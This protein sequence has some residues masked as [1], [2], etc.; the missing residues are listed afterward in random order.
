MQLALENHVGISLLLAIASLTAGAACFQRSVSGG[1]RSEAGFDAGLGGSVA[2]SSSAGGATATSSGVGGSAATSSGVGGGA[3][4]PCPGDALWMKRFG[5]GLDQVGTGVAVS[6]AGDIVLTG[7]FQGSIDLGGGPLPGDPTNYSVYVAQLDPSGQHLWSHAYPGG[8]D[9]VSMGGLPAAAVAVSPSGDVILG[10]D[11]T[12]TVDFGAGPFTASTGFGDGFVV[13]FDPAGNPRWSVQ[14]SDDPGAPDPARPQ[15]VESVAVD[16]AGNVLVLGF[17]ST[18]AY[19]AMFAVKLDP[20]GNQLWRRDLSAGGTLDAT[21]RADAAGAVV[22]AGITYSA[23]DFG[24]IPVAA[25][26][27]LGTFFRGQLD[28]AGA[29]MWSAGSLTVGLRLDPGNGVGIDPAGNVVVAGGGGDINLDVG[30]GIFP[31]GWTT[32][33]MEFDGATGDCRWMTGFADLGAALAVSPT[34]RALVATD[35][36]DRLVSYPD[37]GPAA[38]SS[39]CNQTFSPSAGVE[40]HGLFAAPAGRV[41]MTGAFSSSANFTGDAT[42]AL[43]SAGQ[44]DV[45][46]ASF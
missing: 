1:H 29:E 19:G 42:L 32:K 37:T 39:A 27:A 15:M 7:V 22:V 3:M 46:V 30:C 23:V 18:G 5:D 21:L 40:V 8:R 44:R 9:F 13:A 20:D 16:A 36:G 14:Y 45:F 2:A 31:V 6:P 33:V 10:G 41:I 17:R 35:G 26:P 34:G 25:S 28:P 24:G 38:L 11:F 12:G 43:Q 4:A